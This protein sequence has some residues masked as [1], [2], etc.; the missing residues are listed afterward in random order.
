MIN[1]LKQDQRG[2]ASML[3]TLIM[4]I[5]ISIIVIGFSQIVRRNQREA[6]DQQLSTQAFYAAETGVNDTANIIKANFSN[7]VQPQ[8]KTSCSNS[9]QYTTLSPTLSSGVG[10][11]CVMVDPAPESLLYSSIDLQA[12]TVVPIQVSQNL[13]SLTFTWSADGA[14]TNVAACNDSGTNLP[15]AT[16]WTC[17]FGML[18]VD[19]V[20]LDGATLTGPGLDDKTVTFFFKPASSASATTVSNFSGQRSYIINSKCTGNTCTATVSFSATAQGKNYYAR[21]S[22]LYRSS[23]NLNITGQMTDGNAAGFIGA[24]V[25]VDSTGKAQDQLRRISVRIP[26]T[27]SNVDLLPNNLIQSAGSICK[28][29]EIA[30]GIG[31]IPADLC[32]SM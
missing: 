28:R 14:I 32:G 22:S 25:V 11:T 30:N 29:Y 21:M 19:L 9:G 24:Q 23:K 4:I 10:Y 6:L 31:P 8:A 1:D 20:Q 3:I 27:D 18:R 17:S 7:G 15:T 5:V 26:L 2:V 16:A 13:S 12:S